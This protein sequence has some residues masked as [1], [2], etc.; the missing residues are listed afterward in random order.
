MLNMHAFNYWDKRFKATVHF[1]TISYA[2]VNFRDDGLTLP[3]MN[4]NA[5]FPQSYF[6]VRALALSFSKLQVMQIRKPLSYES[7][8]S[9]IEW[10]ISSMFMLN[11]R[12]IQQGS[13]KRE[14][15]MQCVCIQLTAKPIVNGKISVCRRTNLTLWFWRHHHR[16]SCPT[17]KQLN[18]DYCA[19]F[20]DRR[21]FD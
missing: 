15:K 13:K 18:F 1:N 14:T 9:T 17:S 21:V 4:N 8:V 6:L 12:P 16:L 10:K 5:W 7:A 11:L 20:L 19:R 2:D 3:A